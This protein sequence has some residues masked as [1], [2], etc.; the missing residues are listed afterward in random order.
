D[1][2]QK[3]SFIYDGTSWQIIAQ[4]GADG[5]DGHDGNSGG[6][7]S[8]VV[9]GLTYIETTEETIDGE[10]YRV[11]S[12]ADVVSPDGYLYTYYKYYYK[13]NKLRRLY[14]FFHDGGNCL[15]YHYTEF[16]EHVCN[17]NVF[18][19]KHTY[20]ENGKLKTSDS[21]SNGKLSSSRTYYENGN[22]KTSDSYSNGE[23]YLSHTYYENGKLKTSDSYSNGELYLSHT[24]YDNGKTETEKY[25]SDGEL[26]LSR[27]YYDNGNMKTL[28][29]YSNGELSSSEGRYS[30]NEYMY[31]ISYNAKDNTISAFY[32][33]YETSYLKYYYTSGYVYEYEDGVTKSSSTSASIYSSKTE[34]SDEEAKAL[35][36]VFK[37]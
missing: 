17:E 25:Y 26:Y 27:T 19:T 6:G 21:Y 20:D 18:S 14:C 9:N 24:Y 1:T 3:K 33:Y 32:Y 35:I 29:S 12:Y 36:A 11:E 22:M 7:N 30:N 16:E 10:T 37:M 2:T 13:N 5:N 8:S 4:D 31:K 28:D 23:L 15:N 34:C